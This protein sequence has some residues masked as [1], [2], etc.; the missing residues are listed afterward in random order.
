MITL[1]QLLM[2]TFI[3]FFYRYCAI[4]AAAVAAP[5]VILRTIVRIQGWTA[6]QPPMCVCEQLWVF[7]SGLES[8]AA[9]LPWPDLNQNPEPVA[10]S[11]TVAWWK[12]DPP[13]IRSRLAARLRTIIRTPIPIRCCPVPFYGNCSVTLPTDTPSA[14]PYTP[15]FSYFCLSSLGLCGWR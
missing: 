6:Q 7:R 14:D 9:R 1:C 11:Q 13:P 5:A 3:I 8:C 10:G 12:P 4:T 2:L 15:I